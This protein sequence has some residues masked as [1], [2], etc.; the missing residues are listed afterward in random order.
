MSTHVIGELMRLFVVLGPTMT[1]FA[2]IAQ[3]A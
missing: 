1:V 2:E 3:G